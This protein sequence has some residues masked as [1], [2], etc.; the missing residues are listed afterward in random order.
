MRDHGLTCRAPERPE[1]R[2]DAIL[3]WLRLLPPLPEEVGGRIL[4]VVVRGRP[5]PDVET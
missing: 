3:L 1:R 2:D 5:G 4:R